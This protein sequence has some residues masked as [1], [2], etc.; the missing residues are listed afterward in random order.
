[1][2]PLKS[3]RSTWR[4][5][6][7]LSL[8]GSHGGQVPQHGAS[9]PQNGQ[10]GRLARCRLTVLPAMPGHK[11]HSSLGRLDAHPLL[12]D[13]TYPRR[14]CPPHPPVMLGPSSPVPSRVAP[15]RPN[16]EPSPPGPSI[17]V[18]AGHATACH[19]RRATTV[20]S[21]Q[22][23][24]LQEGRCAG[25]PPLTCMSGV[26]RNC[27]GMQGSIHRRTG[28]QERAGRPR[29]SALTVPRL[30]LTRA[31]PRATVR[32]GRTHQGPHQF[33]HP[34]TGLLDQLTETVGPLHGAAEVLGPL[35]GPVTG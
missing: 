23:R 9:P 5:W 12:H 16:W 25:R 32:S 21:G 2:S 35:V 3:E 15:R 8:L 4:A 28:A 10:R 11:R 1:M 7:P 13:R 31:E 20:A 30:G 22:S 26:G 17:V 14:P 24:S 33:T 19:T 27:M 29:L 18:L 34:A 6:R